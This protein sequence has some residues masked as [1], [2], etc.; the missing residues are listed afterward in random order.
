[1]APQDLASN[2]ETVIRDAA[3]ILE[4]REK[5]W[6][7]IGGL[8]VS[9]RSEPRFTRDVDLAIAVAGDAEAEELVRHF[10]ALGYR[11]LGV[12]EQEAVG[13]LATV[14]L[15]PPEGADHGVILDLLFASSGIE[16]EIVDKAS[17]LEVFPDLEIPVARPSEL[18]ALKVLARDDRRRPQDAADLR[19]LL[20]IATEAEVSGAREALRLI[21]SRGYHRDRDLEADFEKSLAD[22]RI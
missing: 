16:P 9:A 3:R 20:A 22:A 6:A 8:A 5:G 10:Q 4:K 19:S 21:L 12:L 7:L 14:R 15:R 17:L 2:L 18:L 1:M 11:L 13:R